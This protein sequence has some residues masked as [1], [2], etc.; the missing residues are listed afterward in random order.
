LRGLARTVNVIQSSYNFAGFRNCLLS[1]CAR[2]GGDETIGAFT[3]GGM[4]NTG[5]SS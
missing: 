2:A 3:G 1:S 4:H 5:K